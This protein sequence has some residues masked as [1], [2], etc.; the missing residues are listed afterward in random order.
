MEVWENEYPAD[1]E[2]VHYYSRYVGHVE[3]ANII[4]TLN[5]QMHELYTLINSV[6]GDKAFFAYAPDKWTLKEVI[7]HMIETERLF[8]YRAFAIS[9]GEKQPLPGMDQDEYMA[10]NYYNK[11][12]LANLSNEYLAVRV[13]TIHLL[14]SMTKEMISKRGIASGFDVTVRA[15][16][17]IIA[18]HERHHINMIKEKYLAD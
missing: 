16:A 13:S 12:T 8:C 10:N 15:L 18:G 2:Y 6:P 9:R 1:S 3:K 14:S 7:G 5:A 4:N 11:R 17:F